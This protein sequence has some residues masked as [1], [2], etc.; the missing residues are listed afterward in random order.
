MV[1]VLAL[2]VTAAAQADV[3]WGDSVIREETPVYTELLKREGYLNPNEAR[4]DMWI[5]AMLGEKGAYIGAGTF[6]A[7][8]ASTYSDYGK[9]ILID[10]DKR[11]VDFNR[12]QLALLK[13]CK[14]RAEY[15]SY[16]HG[17][18]IPPEALKDEK[19]WRSYFEFTQDSGTKKWSAQSKFQPM[20]KDY[21]KALPPE[22][23]KL[24]EDYFFNRGTHSL[25]GQYPITG[26]DGVSRS[27]PGLW[28]L[29]EA[30]EDLTY[31]PERAPKYNWWKTNTFVDSNKMYMTLRQKALDDKFLVMQGSVAGEQ[32]MADIAAALKAHRMPLSAF[33]V[34]NIPDYLHSP[35]AVKTFIKNL[36]ALSFTPGGQVLFTIEERTTPR[37]V[38]PANT[39]SPFRSQWIYNARPA[40]AFIAHA[41][42][43][44]ATHPTATDDPYGPYYHERYSFSYVNDPKN[45]LRVLNNGLVVPRESNLGSARAKLAI[46]APPT[47]HFSFFKPGPLEWPNPEYRYF[48]KYNERY[49]ESDCSKVLRMMLPPDFY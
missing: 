44:V 7:L 8:N 30:M 29:T 12:L 3:K 11:V 14:T 15:L 32:T 13:H 35:E 24:F 47:Q 21:W 16:M 37:T 19:V 22:D 40:E 2:G 33:D 10:L 41:E 38:F 43:Y 34:S 48:K 20:P 42:Q 18:V 25:I 4:A 36:K 28:G 26:L 39:E 23:A 45:Q 46:D 49:P 6:R 17:A 5:P 9:M 1:C 27:I 31:Y